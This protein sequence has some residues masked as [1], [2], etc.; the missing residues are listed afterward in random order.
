MS[1]GPMKGR[2]V[3]TALHESILDSYYRYQ[4][5]TAGGQVE[6]ATLREL[7]LEPPVI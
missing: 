6:G 4:G 3:D 1:R 7:G 2:K 5:W